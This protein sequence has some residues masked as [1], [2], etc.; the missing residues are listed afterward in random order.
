MPIGT[1][2]TI[3]MNSDEFQNLLWLSASSQ[4]YILFSLNTLVFV[5]TM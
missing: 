3:S 5:Q 2:T 1:D 4:G